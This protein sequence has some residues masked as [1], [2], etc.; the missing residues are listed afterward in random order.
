[1]HL[2]RVVLS[3]KASNIIYNRMIYVITNQGEVLVRIFRLNK[4][5]NEVQ[6][7]TKVLT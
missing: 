6:W 3:I 4:H 1:M 5:V 2:Q 7:N